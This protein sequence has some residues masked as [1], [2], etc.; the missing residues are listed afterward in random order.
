MV[1]LFGGIDHEDAK[2]R[3]GL[4]DKE[5]A[6]SLEDLRGVFAVPPLARQA[7]E[8]RKFDRLENDR[9]AHHISSRRHNPPRLWRQ[10]FF[11]IT[12]RLAEYEVLLEWLSAFPGDLW[13]LPSAGRRTGARWTRRVCFGNTISPVS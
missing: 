6:C 1:D 5:D 13:T 9:I 3:G 2:K 8:G 10:C 4:P 11:S 12:L 7:D